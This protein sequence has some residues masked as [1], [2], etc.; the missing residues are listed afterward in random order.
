LKRRKQ[1]N[2]EQQFEENQRKRE[3]KEQNLY[4]NETGEIIDITA[5]VHDKKGTGK[6][7]R[8]EKEEIEIT[9]EEEDS[10]SLSPTRIN[11]TDN[12]LYYATSAFTVLAGILHLLLVQFFIGFD[13]N[14]SIFL[15]VAGIAQLFWAVPLIKDGERFGI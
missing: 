7:I 1:T 9:V 10:S 6:T 8:I 14:S 15:F 13:S 5:S 4:I 2:E 3:V 12:A 11:T